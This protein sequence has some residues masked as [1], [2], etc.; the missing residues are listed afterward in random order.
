MPVVPKLLSSLLRLGERGVAGLDQVHR[1]QVLVEDLPAELDVD[2]VDVDPADA[3]VLPRRVGAGA[4][5]TRVEVGLLVGKER[6]DR[7]RRRLLHRL[8]ELDALEPVERVDGLFRPEMRRQERAEPHAEVRD[9]P[10]QVPLRGLPQVL[11]VGLRGSD[12]RLPGHAGEG[13]EHVAGLVQHPCTQIG[14]R[15]AAEAH[16]GVVAELDLDHVGSVIRLQHGMGRLDDG[17]PGLQPLAGGHAAQEAQGQDTY[18]KME[19]VSAHRRLLSRG[20]AEAGG[21]RPAS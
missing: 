18:S 4:H 3:Q 12:Q 5:R 8:G 21:L 17:G 11:Q 7:Q 20:V 16:R 10:A 1:G 15:A 2:H 9:A 6:R 19:S 13:R 14:Q